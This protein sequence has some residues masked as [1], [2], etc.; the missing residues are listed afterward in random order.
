MSR[1]A[2]E[3]HQEA[4]Q[5]FFRL[6]LSYHFT[7]TLMADGDHPVMRFLFSKPTPEKPVPT[8]TVFGDVKYERTT[9]DGI[10][11]YSVLM[12]GQKFVRD[13]RIQPGDIRGTEFNERWIDSLYRQKELV[14]GQF[15]GLAQRG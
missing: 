15:L 3:I 12:E 11:E 9:D 6:G 13:V 8:I 1:S 14:R 4:S 5:L 10:V 2:A 7:S